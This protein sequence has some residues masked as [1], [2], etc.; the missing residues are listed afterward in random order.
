MHL[1]KSAIWS[2]S[3]CVY[4]NGGDLTTWQRTMIAVPTITA[5]QDAPLAA[6]WCLQHHPTDSVSSSC[7][8][9]LSRHSPSM[10][11]NTDVRCHCVVKTIID[12]YGL[13]FNWLSN[14][15]PHIIAKTKNAPY[16]CSPWWRHQMK[17]F[18]AL[19]S[20]CAWNLWCFFDRRLNER[21]SKHSWGWWFATSSRP[22]WRHRN[23][24]LLHGYLYHD[25]MYKA[26]L[27][28]YNIEPIFYH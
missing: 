13:V 23:A 4:I 8:D 26:Y 14:T 17:T 12:G 9:S 6:R 15:A 21:L 1:K 28:R 2:R 10:S 24:L 22:L 20:I 18:S 19:L 7:Q 11:P 27:H 5:K 25:N 16:H 3:Q